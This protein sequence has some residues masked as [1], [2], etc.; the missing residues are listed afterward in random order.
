MFSE[1]RLG[2]AYNTPALEKVLQEEFGTEALMSDVRHP[3]YAPHPS[4]IYTAHATNTTM[5]KIKVYSRLSISLEVYYTL[6]VCEI[7]QLCV[8]YLCVLELYIQCHV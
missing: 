2:F 7:V 3:K 8:M 6:C 5:A 4:V 1:G